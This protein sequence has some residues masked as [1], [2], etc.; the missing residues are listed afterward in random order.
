MPARLK[1]RRSNRIVSELCIR[2]VQR[3]YKVTGY[4]IEIH[5]SVRVFLFVIGLRSLLLINDINIY[6][7][8]GMHRASVGSFQLRLV[9]RGVPR[10]NGIAVISADST[11]RSFAFLARTRRLV[12]CSFQ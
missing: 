4:T 10:V 11:R 9:L 5:D 6:N 7:Y 12:S 8:R 1:I 3:V 2:F